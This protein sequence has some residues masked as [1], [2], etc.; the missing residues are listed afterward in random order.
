[1]DISAMREVLGDFKRTDDQARTVR[2]SYIQTFE[3]VIECQPTQIIEIGVRAG[4]YAR[5]ILGAAPD[6]MYTGIDLD[7]DQ[8]GG[9]VGYWKHAEKLLAPFK[10]KILAPMDSKDLKELPL[11]A[12]FLHVDGEHTLTGCTNDLLLGMNCQTIRHIMVDDYFWNEE[13][14]LA[15]NGFGDD[16]RWRMDKFP[17]EPVGTFKHTLGKVLFTRI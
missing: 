2:L 14:Q 12:D 15:C 11:G 16:P 6:A 17:V 4:Y 3:I 8:H 13:V 1:M 10:A 9:R 7:T 5:M